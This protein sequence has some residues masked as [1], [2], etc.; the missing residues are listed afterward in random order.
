[1]SVPFTIYPFSLYLVFLGPIEH[2]EYYFIFFLNTML[3]KVEVIPFILP[4]F[5]IP[6]TSYPSLFLDL[7]HPVCD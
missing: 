6:T 4:L 3:A 1:M 7:S 2:K 5:R